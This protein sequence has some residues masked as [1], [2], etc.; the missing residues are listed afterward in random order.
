VIRKSQS[1]AL[2]PASIQSG[3]NLATGYNIVPG[4]THF[5]PFRLLVVGDF[6]E[7]EML[8]PP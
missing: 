5:L 6:V 7:T 3:A 8:T 1:Y 4:G 2:A